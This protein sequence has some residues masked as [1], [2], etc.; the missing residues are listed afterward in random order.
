VRAHGLTL[1]G[2]EKRVLDL[3]D[4][5]GVT[6]VNHGTVPVRVRLERRGGGE[7]APFCPEIRLR[8][9]ERWSR[10]SG[11]IGPDNLA[12]EVVRGTGPETVRLS[13]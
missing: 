1:T 5:R 6:L 3:R 10:G 11:E 7:W 2:G 9:G 12:V 13:F 8:P 4:T